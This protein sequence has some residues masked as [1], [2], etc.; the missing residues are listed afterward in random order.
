MYLLKNKDIFAKNPLS[1]RKNILFF[2]EMY[3]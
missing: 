3:G 2:F 1:F